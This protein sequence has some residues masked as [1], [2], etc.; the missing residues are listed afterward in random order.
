MLEAT[1]SVAKHVS[2]KL[3]DV[4]TGLGAVLTSGQI[5]ALVINLKKGG[6]LSYSTITPTV[7]PIGTSGVYDLALTAS[8]LDTLGVAQINITETGVIA[9]N[10]D[11]SIDVIAFNKS[12]GVRGG[13]TALPNAAAAAS[14][15]LPTFG[16]GAG[17]VNSP[18]G[19]LKPNSLVDTYVYDTNKNPTSWR[20]RVFASKAATD[21]A[22]PMH[23]DGADGEVER[24]KIAATY[25]VDKTLATYKVDRDL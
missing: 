23:A 15:G 4:V 20:I 13:L 3:I 21:A 10:D 22:D 5:S 12:D 24:Y 1:Q 6:V 18:G 2:V 11:L 7:T 19:Q 9:P 8:H 16:T 25:N 14:G 17:Q